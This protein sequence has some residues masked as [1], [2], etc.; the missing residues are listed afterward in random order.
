[1][2]K[3]CPEGT[4]F[5]RGLNRTVYFH[6]YNVQNVHSEC[7]LEAACSTSEYLKCHVNHVGRI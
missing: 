1:M 3:L 7:K 2:E 4:L 6:S 5:L